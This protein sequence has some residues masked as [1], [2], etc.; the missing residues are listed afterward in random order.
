MKEKLM[1]INLKK[2]SK[3]TEQYKVEKES[4]FSMSENELDVYIDSLQNF[5]EIKEFL[6]KITKLARYRK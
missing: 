5:E 4:I 1:H 6:K 2:A 3:E